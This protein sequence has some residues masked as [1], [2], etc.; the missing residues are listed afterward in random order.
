MTAAPRMICPSGSCSRPRSERTRAVIP[1]LVAVRVAAATIETI[2][3]CPSSRQAA[4]P[5][6]NGKTT[7]TTATASEVAPTF[8]S[9]PRSVSSPIAKSRITTPSSARTWIDSISGL[10]SPSS[11]FPTSTPPISSPSTAG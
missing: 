7:P 5:S 2:V 3:L 6:A 1:T 8:K 9:R 10:T 11:D 4:K